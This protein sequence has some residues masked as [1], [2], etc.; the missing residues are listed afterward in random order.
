MTYTVSVTDEGQTTEYDVAEYA[1]EKRSHAGIC[2]L[3]DKQVALQQD[4]LTERVQHNEGVVERAKEEDVFV[5]RVELPGWFI[6]KDDELKEEFGDDVGHKGDTLRVTVLAEDYSEK[7][8]RII[9]REQSALAG[10]YWFTYAW[11]FVPKSVVRMT[12]VEGLT[13]DE[14]LLDLRDEA[15][16]A[17]KEARERRDRKFEEADGWE[18][19]LEEVEG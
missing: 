9:G 16:G 11:N 2:L 12:R 6:F 1:A 13:G 4:E 5:A 10:D 17:A 3:A 7:A 14:D 18:E 8:W 19:K 15:R